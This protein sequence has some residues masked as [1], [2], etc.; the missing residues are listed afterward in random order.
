MIGSNNYEKLLHV[1]NNDFMV[2]DIHLLFYL[3]FIILLLHIIP[4]ARIL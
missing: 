4:L 1:L 3:Y 2:R